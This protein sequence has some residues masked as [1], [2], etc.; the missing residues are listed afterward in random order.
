MYSSI[1]QGSFIVVLFVAV[2]M[3]MARAGTCAAFSADA[4]MSPCGKRLPLENGGIIPA[5][6]TCHLAFCANG[7]GYWISLYDTSF[8]RPNGEKRNFVFFPADPSAPD[9]ADAFGF[10]AACRSA[11]KQPLTFRPPSLFILYRTFIC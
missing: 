2:V 10:S 7:R 9:T 11:L 1:K 6:G 4:G 3:S 5:P 8:Q